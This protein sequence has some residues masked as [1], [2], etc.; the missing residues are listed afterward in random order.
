MQSTSGWKRDQN[1][2]KQSKKIWLK[3]VINLKGQVFSFCRKEGGK[4]RK[5]YQYKPSWKLDLKIKEALL[6][7]NK[8]LYFNLHTMATQRVA[9]INSNNTQKNS[10]YDFSKIT[11]W[12]LGNK[13]GVETSSMFTWDNT[14]KRLSAGA[15]IA[16]AYVLCTRATSS[17]IPNQKFLAQFEFTGYLDF[18]NC[19]DG[20]KIFVEIKEKLIKDPSLIEDLDSNTSYAQGLG[21]GEI[22]IAKSYPSHSNYLPL[23]E[24]QGGQAVDKR[25][26]ISMPALD[27]VSQRTSTLEEKV[28]TSETKITKLEDKWTPQYLGKFVEVGEAYQAWAAM[29]EKGGKLVREAYI[30]RLSGLSN[31]PINPSD[32]RQLGQVRI[33]HG[34]IAEITIKWI[35]RQ[36]DFQNARIWIGTSLNGNNLINEGLENNPKNIQYVYSAWAETT[37]YFAIDGDGSYSIVSL[38]AIEVSINV[39]SWLPRL[40][41]REIKGVGERVECTLMGL[42]SNGEIIQPWM[43]EMAIG[44]VL[45]GEFNSSW[46]A[47]RNWYL[48]FSYKNGYNSAYSNHCWIEVGAE[49]LETIRDTKTKRIYVKKWE[50]TLRWGW[51]DWYK[52]QNWLKLEKFTSVM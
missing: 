29:V 51:I 26:V 28:K 30:E 2:L 1:L 21:I 4:I 41:P 15:D 44:K 48:E 25:K 45:A 24:I 9:M 19:T 42:H 35:K 5:I 40:Y 11:K 46:S 52:G 13:G 47:P 27:E 43:V 10:D 32:R 39:N 23:W 17:P 6:H 8:V 3:K 49:R 38:D 37:L 34:A 16:T 36:W 22:K 31:E 7:S 12:L 20:D 14:S 18:L 50:I 33:P